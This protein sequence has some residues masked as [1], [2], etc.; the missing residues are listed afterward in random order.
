[1]KYFIDTV[2]TIPEGLGF[3]PFDSTHLTWIALFLITTLINVLYYRKANETKRS[4]WR[5]IIAVLLVINELWKMFWLFAGDNYLWTYLPLHLCSINIF[6]IAYHAWK[7]N[8]LLDAVLYTACIPGAIAALLFPTWTELP[9]LNFMHLHSFTLHI[10][11]VLYPIVLMAGGEV[12]P[13]VNDV[14][15]C[16]GIL[17]AEAVAVYGVNLLLDTNYFYLMEAPSGNPLYWFQQ[18]WGNHWL[19]VPILIAAAL[20][21]MFLPVWIAN[22]VKTKK[23]SPEV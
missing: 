6:V 1:M 11:L 7:P 13:R 12:K 10:L 23:T 21:L 18:N 17:L 14:P 20:L 16:L 19:G 3:S 8:R 5:K 22:V 2:E 4:Q 9:V 15:K